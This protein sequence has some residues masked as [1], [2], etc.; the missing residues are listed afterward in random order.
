MAIYYAAIE[1]I[2]VEE[3]VEKDFFLW[4]KIK[5]LQPRVEGKEA[6]IAST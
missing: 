2:H 4:L 5:Q 3:N 6:V 1:N